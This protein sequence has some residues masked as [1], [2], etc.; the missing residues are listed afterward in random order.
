VTFIP[1]TVGKF[2]STVAFLESAGAM[3]IVPVTAI[4]VGRS[5]GGDDN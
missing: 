2:S 4:C 1:T 5:G 3:D